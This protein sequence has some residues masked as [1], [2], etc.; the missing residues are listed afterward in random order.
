M[1]SYAVKCLVPTQIIHYL[2][3]RTSNLS[4]ESD[5]DKEKKEVGKAYFIGTVQNTATRTLKRPSPL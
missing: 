3:L 1:L 5:T 4:T 2:Q